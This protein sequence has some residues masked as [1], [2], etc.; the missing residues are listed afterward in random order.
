MARARAS[1]GGRASSA[2]SSRGRKRAAQQLTSLAEDDE[3]QAQSELGESESD[4]QAQQPEREAEDGEHEHEQEQEQEEEEQ[5]RPAKRAATS[6]RGSAGSMDE[7]EEEQ[8]FSYDVGD[9]VHAGLGAPSGGGEAEAEEEAEDDIEGLSDSA[10]KKLLTKLYEVCRAQLTP[11]WQS[12]MPQFCRRRRL[13]SSA[14]TRVSAPL[15]GVRRLMDVLFSHNARSWLNR[16]RPG[17]ALP[18]FARAAR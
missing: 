4:A 14:L 10:T 12:E 17:Q 15:P 2:A 6:R 5:L 16:R 11:N 13:R 3:L 1:R 18:T 9:A 7:E 8:L